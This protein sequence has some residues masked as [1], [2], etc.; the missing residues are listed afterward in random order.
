VTAWVAAETTTRAPE[1][2]L[3]LGCGIASVLLLLAWRFPSARV[4]G[5]ETQA[6]SVELAQ[7]S[8]AWNGVGDRC[9]VHAG[10]FR[11]A[12]LDGV[13]DLVTG[14]PPYLPIGTG[15]ESRRVQ[16]GPCNFEHLG[17]IEVYCETAARVLAPDGTFVVCEQAAQDARVAAA[18]GAAGLAIAETLPV[19]PR[20]G[21]PPLF[22][23][24]VVRRRRSRARASARRPPLVVRDERGVRTPDCRA[25]RAAMGL[26]P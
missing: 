21:K 11:V 6:I 4:L 24:H 3:D 1:R 20:A 25:M 23:V 16:K 5:I 2:I 13:F 9:A 15:R 26:P 14:T 18:A 22:C 12:T 19:V 10:D 17:G 7:R 8:I